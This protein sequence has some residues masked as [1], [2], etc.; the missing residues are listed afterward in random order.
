MADDQR[1]DQELRDIVERAA[2]RVL[3]EKLGLELGPD[4]KVDPDDVSNDDVKNNIKPIA[5]GVFGAIAA[6][7]KRAG[8]WNPM[9]DETGDSA[10]SPSAED[11]E[12]TAAPTTEATAARQVLE[13]LRDKVV[14][15]LSG[16]LNE[17]L[18]F[19]LNEGGVV[20]AEK[21]EDADV[22]QDLAARI[23]SLINTIGTTVGD[24][25]DRMVELNPETGRLAPDGTKIPVDAESGRTDGD[26]PGGGDESAN[27]LDFDQWK[28]RIEERRSSVFK[29]GDSLQE[30]ISR[31]IEQQAGE[32]G[33]DGNMKLNLNQDFFR[34]H[35][36][37]MLQQAFQEISKKFVPPKIEVT[38]PMEEKAPVEPVEEDGDSVKLSVNLDLASIFGKFFKGK[39][40][41]ESDEGDESDPNP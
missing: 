28:K 29:L 6:D 17:G 22:Q 21:L 40:E 20:D 26:A 14:R 10:P 18:G 25:R 41:A 1:N 7:L 15:S 34:E 23:T 13:A 11:S 24:V 3:S 39:P 8:Y 38:L 37:A 12:A 35:G 31:F 36:P 27:V 2:S 5:I 19:P 33:P 9:P 4:G 30:S 16:K 32:V